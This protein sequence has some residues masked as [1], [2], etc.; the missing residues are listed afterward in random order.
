[1]KNYPVVYLS[2][3]ILFKTALACE[4]IW[5]RSLLKSNKGTQR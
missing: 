5:D 4:F 1:L 2:Y 3:F